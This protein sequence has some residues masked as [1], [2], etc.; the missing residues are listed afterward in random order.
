MVGQRDL[1]NEICSNQI[2]LKLIILLYKKC[3]LDHFTIHTVPSQ[4]PNNHQISNTFGIVQLAFPHF[5]FW[6][7]LL[8]IFFS[9]LN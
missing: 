3:S 1:R 6:L 5:I 8:P 4:K 7:R 2:Y 9:P